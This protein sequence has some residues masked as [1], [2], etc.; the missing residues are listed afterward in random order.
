VYK[1]KTINIYGQF[2]QVNTI[3]IGSDEEVAVNGTLKLNP[4][5]DPV[6]AKFKDVT[7][8]ISTLDGG[9]VKIDPATGILTGVT[10]GNVTITA[11]ST[12]GYKTNS[13]TKKIKINKEVLVEGIT[14]DALDNTNTSVDTIT[15]I[16]G[17]LNM[18][19]IVTSTPTNKDV[20]W[21]VEPYGGVTGT[22]EKGAANLLDNLNG[23]A[24]L[25][26]VSN[27]KVRVTA[28]AKDG[29]GKVGEKIITLTNQ[30]VKMT[31]VTVSGDLSADKIDTNGGTLQMAA[32]LAPIDATIPASVIWSVETVSDA[33]KGMTG[34]AKIDPISGLLSAIA[35]GT[36]NVKAT[37]T[38]TD[39]TKYV[40]GKV[41]T[42]NNQIVIVT[43]IAITAPV[44]TVG[45]NKTL[46][47]TANITTTTTTTSVQTKNVKWV[48]SDTTK[49]NIDTDGVLTGITTG[50]VTVTATSTDDN[51]KIA[52]K[53]IPI[54]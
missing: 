18:N 30:F 20:I 21:K 33:G 5:I 38:G 3:N 11:I 4:I 1:A 50:G 6:G 35:N 47:L 15:T 26:A 24:K 54:G 17:V 45:I 32:I 42:L 49:A 10:D 23:T 22:E 44:Y 36:V 25:T 48:V 7:W 40:V 29:S 13:N 39:G 9:S 19:A 37:V 31:G 46:Q 51:S 28:T 41:I 34:I 52:T 12:D 53:Y 14:V 16:G 43:G 27:G 8:S 2:V